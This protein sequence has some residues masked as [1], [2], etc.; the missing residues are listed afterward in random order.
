VVDGSGH[1]VISADN[2]AT[3]T[4]ADTSESGLSGIEDVAFGSNMV[5]LADYYGNIATSA[6]NGATWMAADTSESGLSGTYFVAFGNNTFVAAGY[7][8]DYSIAIA[9]Y[10]V[11]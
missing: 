7:S 5:V 9:Y 2:G 4:T 11:N 3:W 1:I 8:S 10:S 6:D